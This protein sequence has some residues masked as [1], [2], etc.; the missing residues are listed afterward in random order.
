MITATIE[1]LYRCHFRSDFLFSK[2][3]TANRTHKIQINL[4]SRILGQPNIS[5]YLSPNFC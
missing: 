2:T 3:F 5:W 4:D 1:K